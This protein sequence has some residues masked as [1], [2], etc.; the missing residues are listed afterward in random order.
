MRDTVFCFLG[1]AVYNMH[2]VTG[3]PFGD[4]WMWGD[5]RQYPMTF[6]A[7]GKNE[8]PTSRPVEKVYIAH[9]T[10]GIPTGERNSVHR[11]Y[12]IY[13]NMYA[14]AWNNPKC[15]QAFLTS[16]PRENMP[17]YIRRGGSHS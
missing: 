3:F 15:P 7:P 16:D 1:V 2:L 10:K 5:A 8:R 13:L 14:P 12:I 17:A 4:I 6:C 11:W 9:K